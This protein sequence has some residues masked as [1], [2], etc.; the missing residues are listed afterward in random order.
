V[1]PG[2]GYGP[3][4]ENFFRLSMTSPDE[5]IDQGLERLK[6]FIKESL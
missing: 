2:I 3:S 6:A 4:G 5:R 1:T